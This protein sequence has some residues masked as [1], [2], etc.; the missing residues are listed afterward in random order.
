MRRIRLNDVQR[1]VEVF[2]VL[3]LSINVIRIVRPDEIMRISTAEYPIDGICTLLQYA[4]GFDMLK[5]LSAEIQY[6][7]TRHYPLDVD[8]AR[9]V[10]FGAD[11][12]I[13]RSSG[14]GLE[15]SNVLGIDTARVTC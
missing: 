8:N 4:G 2:C 9:S 10:Q 7:I 14:E 6:H 15:P 11:L 3:G 12:L 13:G 5:I 1:L